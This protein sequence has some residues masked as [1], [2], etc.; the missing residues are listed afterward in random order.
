MCAG[1][2]DYTIRSMASSAFPAAQQPGKWIA[3]R[4]QPPVANNSVVDR[5]KSIPKD[6]H[7]SPSGKWSNNKHVEVSKV[8]NHDGIVP[9][10]A[11]IAPDQTRVSCKPAQRQPEHV[12]SAYLALVAD[13]SPNRRVDF[14][15]RV[16]T[17]TKRGDDQPV[18][19]FVQIVGSEID[20]VHNSPER[21]RHARKF[22]S[23][24]C[25]APSTSRRKRSP[26]QRPRCAVSSFAATANTHWTHC[27]H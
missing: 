12:R 13:A 4:Q 19:R 3:W 8:A 21:N 17:L 14:G 18:P 15:H 9:W 25:Q 6:R 11:T 26:A 10:R 20:N 7:S 16:S 2:E 24:I 5:K 27:S 23:Q 22:Q 1:V